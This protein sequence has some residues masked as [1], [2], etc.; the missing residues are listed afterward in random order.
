MSSWSFWAGRSLLFVALLSRFADA[1]SFAQKITRP[2]QF[3]QFTRA[4]HCWELQFINHKSD[5]SYEFVFMS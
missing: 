5:H 2:K 1:F 4:L 3:G